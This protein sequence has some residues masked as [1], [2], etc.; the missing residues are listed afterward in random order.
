[1][2]GFLKTEMITRIQNPKFTTI[3]NFSKKDTKS[4]LWYKKPNIYSC[5]QRGDLEQATIHMQLMVADNSN[6][7]K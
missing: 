1:M 3:L 2:F 6:V 4:L 7:A 5:S